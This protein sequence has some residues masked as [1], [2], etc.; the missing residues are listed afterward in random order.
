MDWPTVITGAVLLGVGMVSSA[1]SMALRQMS[2]GRLEEELERIGRAEWLDV[3]R[4]RQEDFM[5]AAAILRM[6][7]ALLLVMMIFDVLEE[8]FVH[9]LSCYVTV[10]GISG[11]LLT[12]FSVAIPHAWANYAGEPLLARFMPVLVGLYYLLWPILTVTRV[13]DELV[14]R[15][16]GVSIAEGEAESRQVEQDVMDAVSEANIQGA[17]GEREK[18]MIE[19]V[20]GLD[21]TTAAQ[22][23]TPRIDLAAAPV[24]ATLQE[25]K[26][27]IRHQGHSRIPIYSENIDKILGM[28]YAKD[29]LQISNDES[30]D[31]SRH[32]RSVPFVPE[33]KSL[34]DLL[35]EFQTGKTH[36]AIVLD[37]YGG[38]AGLVTIEDIL[39][40]LVGEITDEYEPPEPQPIVTI[41]DHVVEVDSKVPVDRINETFGL[42]LPES[43]EYETIGGFIFARL[44]RIPT[45][46]EK[47]ID[48]HVQITVIEAEDRRIK[49]LRLERLNDASS[50]AG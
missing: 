37:E 50:Q 30:F 23:M 43:D 3:Y 5:L 19:K 8:R 42:Q 9:P 16:C 18:V 26:D 28:I 41:S 32:L 40:E 39:E 29:L 47:F 24:E 17:V 27:I 20:M 31:A 44:G 11:A 7:C 25:L 45:T 46:G 15:L 48:D 34:R 4:R 36:A 2:L 21:E 10:F 38:T 1:L 12:V 14:R 22:I 13:F 49:R 35:Q 6:G 33:S